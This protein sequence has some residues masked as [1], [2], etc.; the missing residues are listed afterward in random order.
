MLPMTWLPLFA[1]DPHPQLTQFVPFGAALVG[2]ISGCILTLVA[3]LGTHLFTR[4][5]LKLKFEKESCDFIRNFPRQGSEGELEE[6]R[7]IR[8]KVENTGHS[9][10]KDCRG[11]VT[12]VQRWSTGRNMWV[13]T[14]PTYADCLRLFWTYETATPNMAA[15]VQ[16]YEG[17]DVFPNVPQYLD[18]FLFRIN[19]QAIMLRSVVGQFHYKCL[20]PIGAG[21]KYRITVLVSAERAK[22]ITHELELET[23]SLPDSRNQEGGQTF[24][25][26]AFSV[27][28]CP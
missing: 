1:E 24:L 9:V 3:A 28:S 15:A 5:R 6:G 13:P 10:A 11:Y 18:V 27:R 2:A 21:E 20:F 14:N 23:H 12:N 19:A 4:P 26:A 8:I 7:L 16:P 22:Y 17:I 25:G